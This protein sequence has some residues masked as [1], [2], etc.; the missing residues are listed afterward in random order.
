MELSAIHRAKSLEKIAAIGTF[1]AEDD[2]P[3]DDQ[4]KALLAART[5]SAQQPTVAEEILLPR[6]PVRNDIDQH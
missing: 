2:L 4:P 5:T 1:V 6:K 3:L